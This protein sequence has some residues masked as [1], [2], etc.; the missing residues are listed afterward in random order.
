[1]SH[2]AHTHPRQDDSGI[3]EFEERD[4]ARSG[5]AEQIGR[6][7]ANTFTVDRDTSLADGAGAPGSTAVGGMT[8]DEAN[9]RDDS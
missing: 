7:I 1:M 2:P 6:N 3:P 5:A 9:G 8:R 4:T